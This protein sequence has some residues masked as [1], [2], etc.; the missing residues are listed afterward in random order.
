MTEKTKN[1][2]FLLGCFVALMSFLMSIELAGRRIVTKDAA[3]CAA[4]GG[5]YVKAAAGGYACVKR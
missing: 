3:A 1:D 5:V 2:L 4:T